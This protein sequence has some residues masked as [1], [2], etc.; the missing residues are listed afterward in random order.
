[1]MSQYE[2]ADAE[3][4]ELATHGANKERCP[5]HCKYE[6]GCKSAEEHNDGLDS[7]LRGE[8]NA[9]ACHREYGNGNVGDRAHR[10]ES[11]G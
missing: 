7:H 11:C 2:E 5:P 4:G 1:M 3:C 6:K 8:G 10:H 9:T